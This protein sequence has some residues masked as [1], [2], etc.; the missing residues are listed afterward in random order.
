MEQTHARGKCRIIIYKKFFRHIFRSESGNEQNDANIKN[1]LFNVFQNIVKRKR[2]RPSLSCYNMV[3]KKK[4]TK[5]I[6]ILRRIFFKIS[7]TDEPSCR[8]VNPP[9]GEA[10]LIL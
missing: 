6:Q 3:L 8:V 1:K 4:K 10:P 9:G 2:R 5:L 7:E